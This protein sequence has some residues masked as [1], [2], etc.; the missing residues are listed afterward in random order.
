MSEAGK[1][2]LVRSTLS[3]ESWNKILPSLSQ[4]PTT[5]HPNV[6]KPKLV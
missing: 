5:H 1:E 6:F 4:A 2:H 3:N